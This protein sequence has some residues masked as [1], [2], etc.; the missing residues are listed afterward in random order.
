MNHGGA[1]VIVPDVATAPVHPK[2]RLQPFDLG[3]KLRQAWL[4]LCGV[5]RLLKGPTDRLVD[6]LDEK[7]RRIHKLCSA[8]RSI[9]QL[10][11]TDGCVL[12]DR[13]LTL[14]G[15]GGSIEVRDAPPKK[16]I[17]VRGDAQTECSEEDLLRPLGHRHR[18]AYNLCKEVPN[19]LAF[20]ISQDGDLRLFA[21]DESAVS[22]YDSLHG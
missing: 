9:G 12:F 4:S 21:S 20:V 15:F 17:L 6:L 1:F 16:C 3:K 18:S 10:S 8:S 13:T 11:A 7:R 19:S 2:Y 14:H 5:W 22:W